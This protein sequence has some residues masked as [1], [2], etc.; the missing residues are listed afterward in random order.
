MEKYIGPL[1]IFLFVLLS[2]FRDVFYG[3]T[4]QH[5]SF[6]FLIGLS[7]S[8]AS[9]VFFPFSLWKAPR[10][11]RILFRHWPE[12]LALNV[13]TALAWLAYFSAIKWIEP[14]IV[15]TIWSGLGPLIL[16][17]FSWTG[18]GEREKLHSID[19]IAQ[20]GVL[21]SILYLVWIVLSQRS[22]LPTTQIT[23]SILGLIAT[24]VS[25]TFIIISVVL[26]KKLNVLKVGAEAIVGTRFLLLALVSF[27]FIWIENGALVTIGQFAFL[28]GLALLMI[29]LPIYLFQAGLQR[30]SNFTAEAITALGPIF[31][32]IV[33]LF[34]DRL[35]FS[36]HSLVAISFYSLSCSGAVW[37]RLRVLSISIR[38]T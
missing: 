11:L 1:F 21:S 12:I 18:F 8:L 36:Y 14:A 28:G 33:Q 5:V 24:L 38:S 34:D 16:L 32:F 10:D 37:A 30:S 31:V 29:V 3:S 2:S 26:S 25:A 27:A 7:F 22:G 15:N 9:F 17:L 35:V 13:T 4:F 20:I 23:Q 19:K 6:F